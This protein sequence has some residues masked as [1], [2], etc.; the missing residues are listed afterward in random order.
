MGLK[1]KRRKRKEK[2][3]RMG[4]KKKGNILR[5]KKG[6]IKTDINRMEERKRWIRS[7]KRKDFQRN[8]V[9]DQKELM[10]GKEPMGPRRSRRSAVPM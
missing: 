4:Q 3:K 2:K 7:R 1:V 6:E 5:M 9:V 10:E 8:K